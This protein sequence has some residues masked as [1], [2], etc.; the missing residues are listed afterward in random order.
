MQNNDP[1]QTQYK[2]LQATPSGYLVDFGDG[3]PVLVPEHVMVDKNEANPTPGLYE[4][5]Q[6]FGG[7][8][9]A[10]PAQTAAQAA[11]T[12][13]WHQAYPGSGPQ[14]GLVP[15][16]PTPS[17]AGIPDNGRG[18][19][20]GGEVTSFTAEDKQILDSLPADAKVNL[21]GEALAYWQSIHPEQKQSP[22]NALFSVPGQLANLL[23]QGGQPASQSSSAGYNASWAGNTSDKPPPT[24]PDLSGYENDIAAAGKL[25]QQYGE[26][27]AGFAEKQ[28]DLAVQAE[29]A[30]RPFREATV[31]SVED[32]QKVLAAL[33]ETVNE[34]VQSERDRIMQRVA[35]VPRVDPGKIWSSQPAWQNALGLLSAVT[36]GM[37]AVTTG[38]GKNMGLE[39]I[40]R[41]IDRDVQAQQAN[42][43]NEWKRVAHD[44][45]SLAQ[46]QQWK[47]TQRE[48]ALEEGIMRREALAFAMETEKGKYSSLSKQAE[49][50]GLA[51]GARAI[52]ADKLEELDT[53]RIN[54][55]IAEK[56]TAH[57]QWATEVGLSHEAISIGAKAAAD[58]AKSGPK[59][60]VRISFDQRTGK[61]IY[62]PGDIYESRGKTSVDQA[63][64]QYKIAGNFL[65]KAQQLKDFM[66]T[67][68]PGINTTLKGFGSAQR[69]QANAMIYG[70]AYELA[71]VDDKG[72]KSRSDIE[73]AMQQMGN[74]ETYLRRGGSPVLENLIRMK[75]DDKQ[76]LIRDFGFSDDAAVGTPGRPMT[77][78]DAQTDIR[79]PAKPVVTSPETAKSD[80][81]HAAVGALT[82]Q[83]PEQLTA[84]MLALLNISNND[85]PSGELNNYVDN[86]LNSRELS[87]DGVLLP[88]RG[89]LGSYAQ[90]AENVRRATEAGI[91]RAE[92]A[93][94]YD[95][96]DRLR[97]VG[98]ALELR[99]MNREKELAGEKVYVKPGTNTVQGRGWGP[100][101]SQ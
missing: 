78:S 89:G 87:P 43:E 25:R 7:S 13:Q 71:G 42:I 81:K 80:I 83:D 27:Q 96:A 93:G 77:F 84:N 76:A 36:G 46:Y 32:E 10:N 79:K 34:Y 26:Q 65:R 45:D 66:D 8:H 53:A 72:V 92:S 58:A 39:A 24:A 91:K 11:E 35:A 101:V 15:K 63:A 21:G 57:A 4:Q 2:I 82:E 54:R 99:L 49:L 40:E 37:L 19:A 52:N 75:R 5:Q 14:V 50:D 33:D 88:G 100:Q 86:A 62:V 94:Q 22:L 90:G 29:E 48:H 85:D 9:Q 47:A 55:A 41:A 6:Q 59:P 12:A 97:T 98:H 23:P 60:A 3:N 56:N 38:S 18:D 51:A 30:M 28:G 31:K 61:P 74:P 73:A 68:G 69:D 20:P 1:G 64:T 67:F 70:L 16:G 44:K 95:I 17:V